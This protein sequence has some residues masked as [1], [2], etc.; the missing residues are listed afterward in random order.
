MNG[1]LEIHVHPEPQDLI[2]FG[3]RV[4]TD[5]ISFKM[6]TEWVRVNPEAHVTD[7][8]MR[9]I[10]TGRWLGKDGERSELVV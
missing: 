8:L 7:A 1:A 4:F 2:L 6:R 9:Y 3:N 5:G 10:H